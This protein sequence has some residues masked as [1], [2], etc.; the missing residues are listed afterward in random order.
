MLASNIY[1]IYLYDFGE[2]KLN[3]KAKILS[4]VSICVES[5]CIHV[6]QLTFSTM[7]KLHQ[8]KFPRLL[9]NYL[10]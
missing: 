1:R 5:T 2:Q 4:W 8:H 9:Y 10:L 7:L 3:V 6:S